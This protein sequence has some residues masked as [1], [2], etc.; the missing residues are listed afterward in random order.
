MQ[1]PNKGDC[2][3]VQIFLNLNVFLTKAGTTS[4]P[5]YNTTIK[6]IKFLKDQHRHQKWLLRTFTNYSLLFLIELE[7]FFFFLQTATSETLVKASGGECV[8]CET[9]RQGHL[10]LFMK[11]PHNY[12]A[13]HQPTHRIQSC[14][15]MFQNRNKLQS[16]SNKMQSYS[17]NMDHTSKLNSQSWECPSKDL[18]VNE[19]C[20]LRKTQTLNWD[21]TTTYI[22]WWSRG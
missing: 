6:S 18:S 12:Q 14:M 2:F 3:A 10:W 19:G 16:L 22:A 11:N 7:L 8:V 1:N 13:Y 4:R 17:K 5:C 21:T 20:A 9:T 15:L